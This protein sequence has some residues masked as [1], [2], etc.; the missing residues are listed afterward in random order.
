MQKKRH[1]LAGLSWLWL[2]W[3]ESSFAISS[4][5]GDSGRGIIAVSVLHYAR[6]APLGLARPGSQNRYLLGHVHTGCRDEAQ[7]V[8][9]CWVVNESVGDHVC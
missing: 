7:P 8:R 3:A 4:P 2:G 5:S 9:Q 6:F 1:L